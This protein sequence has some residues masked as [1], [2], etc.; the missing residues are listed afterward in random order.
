MIFLG[1]AMVDFEKP[2]E[3]TKDFMNFMLFNIHK[4][5]NEII[6]QCYQ[7]EMEER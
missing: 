5:I 1:I 4:G 6:T 2:E 3:V 7:D